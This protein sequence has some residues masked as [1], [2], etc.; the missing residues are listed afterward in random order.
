MGYPNFI[1]NVRMSI[2]KELLAQRADLEAQIEAARKNELSEAI[3]KVRTLVSDYG[4]TESDIFSKSIK[5]SVEPKYRNE[6]TGETWTGRGKP[7][8]WIASQDREKFLIK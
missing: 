4:L 2:Y 6:E 8:K 5:K 1:Q 3:A 7:P